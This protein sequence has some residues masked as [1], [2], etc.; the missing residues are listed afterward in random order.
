[1]RAR[2]GFTLIEL[3]VVIGILGL[4]VAL[5]LPAVME[6]RETARRASCMNN[7]HNLALAIVNFEQTR[8][9]YPGYRNLQAFTP[10]GMAR[11][12]SW[13]FPLLP[14]FEQSTVHFNHGERGP[15]DQRGQLPNVGI[16]I[17]VCPSD[18][19]AEAAEQY[20]KS[21]NSYIVN[22]GQIDAEGSSQVPADWRSSGIFMDRFPYALD[23]RPVRHEA[24]SS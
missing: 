2:R 9:H 20:E 11:S 5:L 19:L 15:A 17:L 6:A 1:M 8:R 16:S 21:F 12:I 14:Y 18:T 13:V 22:A 10:D 3:L 24:V 4:L 23:G 7:Q